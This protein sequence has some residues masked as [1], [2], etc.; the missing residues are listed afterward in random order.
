MSQHFE[1]IKAVLIKFICLCYNKDLVAAAYPNAAVV[2][3]RQQLKGKTF[4]S[5]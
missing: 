2:R 1:I 4:E 3:P 5:L